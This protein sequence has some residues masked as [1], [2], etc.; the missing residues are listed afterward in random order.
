MNRK[1][2]PLCVVFFHFLLLSRTTR[3]TM[4]RYLLHPSENRS[5]QTPPGCASSHRR[6]LALV[7]I[8]RSV[9]NVAVGQNLRL[10]FWDD[11][12]PMVSFRKA[13]ELLTH[14]HLSFK[15]THTECPAGWQCAESQHETRTEKQSSCL[16]AM[17]AHAE[18]NPTKFSCLAQIEAPCCPREYMS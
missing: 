12:P 17:T 6:L 8:P 18:E 10:L 16:A 7:K 15:E 9:E 4:H 14:S 13:F 3:L 1:P 2:R 5:S 11:Y